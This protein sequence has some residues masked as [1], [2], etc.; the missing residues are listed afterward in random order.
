MTAAIAEIIRNGV[1]F[2]AKNWGD[3]ITQKDNF[4]ECIDALFDLLEERKIN[5]LLVGDVALLSYVDGQNTQDIDLILDRR[6]LEFLSEFEIQ[7]D[8]NDFLRCRF[9]SLQIDLLLT[10]N[11]LFETIIQR[12]GTEREFGSRT[13]RCVTVEGLITLKCYAL[14]SLYC[15]GEFIRRALG[16]PNFDCQQ[17]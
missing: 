10:E 13:V 15:Q 12:F 16:W 6:D 1:Y 8:N 9:A 7:D 14:P 4:R 3:L 2:D 5:Y 17:N 11:E